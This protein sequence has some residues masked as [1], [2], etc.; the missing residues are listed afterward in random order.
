MESH[1]CLGMPNRPRVAS[2]ASLSTS[3]SGSQD[4]WFKL[5]RRNLQIVGDDVVDKPFNGLS[6]QSVEQFVPSQ[7]V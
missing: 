7:S 3:F 1:G 2:P 5:D 4:D 6:L